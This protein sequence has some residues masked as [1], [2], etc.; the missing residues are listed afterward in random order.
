MK[1]LICIS[2][3]AV[4][5]SILA[6]QSLAIVDANK[7]KVN[8]GSSDI[9][10]QYADSVVVIFTE[11]EHSKPFGQGSG[12]LVNSNGVIITNY[13]VIAGSSSALVKLK[14]G[15]KIKAEGIV[16][17]SKEKDLA[18]IK[19]PSQG[20]KYAA[21]GDSDDLEP[22]DAVVAI[23][24]PIG[25]EYSI[26]DGMVSSIRTLDDVKNGIKMIQTSAPLSPGS[27]G[28]PLFNMRGEVIGV[29]V[30]SIKAGQNLN[31]AIPINYA[32]P[33][34]SNRITMSFKEISKDKSL[35]SKED[36]EKVFITK[37]GKKYH[38]AGCRWL[39]KSK[40]IRSITRGEAERNGFTP[41]KTCKP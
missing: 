10:K 8:L 31:F 4:I 30:M 37:T 27:S 36:K 22:G 12:F 35:V 24:A 19:I 21:M 9:F 28:C 3:T 34:I 15:R 2:I 18:I 39:S 6:Y 1:K 5:V 26:S 41:C 23:G 29:C 33:M 13:H 25:L 11:D 16:A 40:S 32:K 14:D 7:G 38:R 20:L 17:I